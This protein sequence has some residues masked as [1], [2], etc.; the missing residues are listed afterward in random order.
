MDAVI[1]FFRFLLKYR[2]KLVDRTMFYLS[3]VCA[4]MTLAHIGYITDKQL[5][6]TS[7]DTVIG[8]FYFLFILGTLR[9]VAAI[10]AERKINVSHISGLV[11][12]VYFLLI[13]VSRLTG[14]V[15]F[16]KM[17]WL[18]LGIALVFLS[19]LSR[20]SLF[21]DNF[22]F[23]PTI[24]F[25]IS[26]LALILLGTVLLMLPRTTLLAPLSFVD[27]LFMAT[28][29]VCI[30]GL[31]VTDIS[32]NF[33]VFGQSVIMLL[34]QIGGLG[35]MTFT[36][37]FGYFFSG[38][39]SYKNQLM[40]GEILGENKLNSVI[41]T[42]LTIIFITLFFELIGG[43]FIFFSLDAALFKSVGDRIFFSAFHAISS[44]CNAGF[45]ILPDDIG[46]DI[47]RFNHGF[48]MIIAC[49]FILGGLG[50]GTVYNFYTFLKQKA[51]Q[52]VYR[53]FLRRPY[54]HKP[55][56]FTFNTRFIL[57][58]NAIVLVVA[59]LSYYIL[60]QRHTLAE[61]SSVIGDWVT[62]FFMANSARSAGF[63]NVNINFVATP[64]LIMMVTLM[65]MGASPGST[66]GG[67]KITTVALAIMNI[68]ALARGKESIEIYKRRIAVESVNKA[69]AIIV[70]SVLTI[71]L[72][73]VL[74]NFTDP[75]QEMKAL[76][77]E[78]VSAYSTCG[79]S[80]GITPS[81]SATGKIIVAVTMFVGRVGTLTLLVAFIKNTRNKSYIYPTEK[82][83]F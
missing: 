74:M 22:Y 24:L 3:M 29:A 34:I 37:F 14:W 75:Q 11:L 52:V 26:F 83:L 70:L 13:S 62:S 57:F 45:T 5:A 82:I 20:N 79:L 77:F 47:Y 44:F 19:E 68:I 32:T 78:V 23:N 16:A 51:K 66:G 33:S 41:S 25:V 17:E 27:A 56:A 10:L 35:I 76:L 60:E 61:E 7:E 12:L 65:W 67:V 2:H 80:L 38:G 64:V 9:T 4:I 21:F 54:I 73:F 71:T 63:D 18:Y 59:T 15:Y 49:S 53:L 6:E 39:F 58:C 43:I 48:Q 28:S 31:T 81:L 50:F 55:R 36:G 42:L 72:S 46:H 30:T 69:F 8:M 1:G 40:F